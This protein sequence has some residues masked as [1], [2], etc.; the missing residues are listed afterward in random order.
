MNCISIISDIPIE[1]D[2]RAVPAAK[3][4]SVS[5]SL[6]AAIRPQPSRQGRM[7]PVIARLVVSFQVF[8]KFSMSIPSPP[9]ITLK[10]EGETRPRGGHMF[11]HAMRI[12]RI[13]TPT[14]AAG[15]SRWYVESE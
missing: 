10:T 15:M 3:P 11:E 8:R 9:S 6:A 14:M 13:S 5:A 4:S 7:V 2:E 1:V 12:D